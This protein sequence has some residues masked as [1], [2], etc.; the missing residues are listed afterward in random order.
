MNQYFPEYLENE[1]ILRLQYTVRVE[2]YLIPPMKKSIFNSFMDE[3]K[4]INLHRAESIRIS[5]RLKVRIHDH[6]ST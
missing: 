2:F 3:R 4:R 5:Y 1:S 6:S